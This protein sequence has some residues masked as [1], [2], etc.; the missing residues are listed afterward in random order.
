M[1]GRNN[2]H[3][4]TLFECLI[5]IALC[6]ILIFSAL[7]SYRTFF[8]DN[9]LT[10]LTDTLE[11]VLHYARYAAITIRTDIKLCARDPDNTCGSDWQNGQ[12]VINANN[13]RVLRVFSALP[14]QF[15]LFWEST[16]GESADLE[17]NPDGFTHGQQ[18]SFFICARDKAALSAKIIILRTGRLRSETGHFAQCAAHATLRCKTVL[19]D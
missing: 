6:S 3:G 12:L 2:T 4:F 11:D 17:W 8:S 7:I 1:Y 16:L 19:G 14:K 18:G 10:I 9:Q 13:A 5:V 15:Q